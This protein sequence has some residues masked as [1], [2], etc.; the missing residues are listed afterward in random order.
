[1]SQQPIHLLCAT[2][3]GYTMPLAVMLTSVVCNFKGSRDLHLHIMESDV[4]D[5]LREKVEASVLKN[6]KGSYRLELHWIKLDPNLIRHLPVGGEANRH[7]TWEAYARLLVAD[8]L[9]PDCE[10]AIYLDCDVV[11]LKDIS[12]L[13]D[14][15][16]HERIISAV[17]AVSL[18]YVSSL[19][20]GTP[21]VFNYAE[22]G[23]PATT[24]YF[25]S[26][27][28]VINLKLWREQNVTARVIDYMERYQDQI[29]Y[30]DQ[31][32]LN[33]VLHDQWHRLDQRWNHT[34]ALYPEIDW[35][36]PAFSREEWLKVKT[37]PF[38]A[39]YLGGDK[40]WKPGF[41]RPRASFFF[42]YLRKT[43]F[44]DEVKMP[45]VAIGESIIGYKNY[46]LLWRIKRTLDSRLSKSNR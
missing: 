35:K 10:R 41:K 8:V 21:V 39:H 4:P 34:G 13:N 43:L 32:G 12:D 7:I 22:L 3:A 33:A 16:D 15:A 31:G 36:P 5:S 28:M 9:P 26:G 14:C 29:L 46:F 45:P 30:H 2:N 44:K 18:P 38:I 11:V 42:R 23:I 25:N 6:K 40:P 24:R 1:M 19:Y 17:A 37:D 27:V 20:N